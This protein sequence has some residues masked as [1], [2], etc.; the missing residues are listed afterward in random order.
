VWAT[1][2]VHSFMPVAA[3]GSGAPGGALPNTPLPGPVCTSYG[4]RLGG[5]TTTA[6]TPTAGLLAGTA[7]GTALG[8]VAIVENSG[9]VL[10]TIPTGYQFVEGTKFVVGKKS[11]V[12]EACGSVGD[13][14][15]G[16]VTATKCSSVTPSA[17]DIIVE[18]CV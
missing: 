17:I 8:W 13:N 12:L 1:P 5:F 16:T 15:N 9:H 14:G 18:R 11:G 2:V 6:S 7:D 10:V 3:A 4:A